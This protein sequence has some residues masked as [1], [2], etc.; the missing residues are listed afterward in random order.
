[1]FLKHKNSNYSPD[2][3]WVISKIKQTQGNK[4]VIPLFPQLNLLN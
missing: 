1:M 3:N 4:S 2:D